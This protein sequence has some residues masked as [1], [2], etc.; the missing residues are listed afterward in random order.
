MR[1]ATQPPPDVAALVDALL[2]GRLTEEQADA[3]AV[4]GP[5]A[6]RLALLAA[7]ARLAQLQSR[8]D[9]SPSTPSG[10]VP[11]YQKPAVRG[12]G[13][14]PGAKA[15][16]EG[17][18]RRTPPQIDA[19]VEHRLEVCPCCGGPLQR[20]KRTRTRIIEDIPQEITPIVTEHAIHRDTARPAR[21]TSSRWWRMPCPTPRWGTT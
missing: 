19:R 11:V 16:H 14:R 21:S 20:C 10:M 7:N 17:S 13:K 6:V 1:T 15:G 3:L 18:R 9:F 12:R 4:A 8:A 5:E 2:H